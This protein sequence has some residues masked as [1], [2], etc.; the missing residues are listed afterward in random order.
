MKSHPVPI[1]SM[2]CR[3][4]LALVLAG[5]PAVLGAQTSA[6]LTRAAAS[7]TARD[8]AR[9]IGIIAADS[10][11]G[12]DTPSRG[13]DLTAQYVADQ[14][15]SFGLKPGG[16]Q[17]SWF[18]RYPITRRRLDLARSRAIFSTAT[19]ADTA[20]F[21]RSA[22]YDGGPVPESPVSGTALLVAGAH[23]AETAEHV[24]VRDK[25]TLY[26]PAS[27]ADRG[28]VQQVLRVLFLAGP[29]ALV[30]LTN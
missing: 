23:T 1:V 7:L 14:F 13:L 6:P 4:L 16:D 21:S 11:M 28:T 17:G 3:F 10:M 20:W 9:R 27:N 2:G 15:R 12:R 18:Q 25:V 24:P 29:K 22:R 8:V 30:V 19:R 26:V 5:F